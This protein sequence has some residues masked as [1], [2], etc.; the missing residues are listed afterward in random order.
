[1]SV[2]TRNVLYGVSLPVF[3][4]C[5]EFLIHTEYPTT[6][7][8]N[9]SA[10]VRT[11]KCQFRLL[12]CLNLKKTQNNIS[13]NVFGLEKDEVYPL[14]ITKSRHEKH[15]SLL[16]ISD[17][18]KRHYCLINNLSRMLGDR[19]KHDGKTFYC[20]YCLHSYTTKGLL[21]AHIVHCKPHGA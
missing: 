14:C 11:W 16:L 20:N 3:I 19:T 5:R 2:T 17:K 7:N 12:T 1:M 4:Q 6:S 15:V 18:D 10:T 21:D 9:R 8:M 13:I